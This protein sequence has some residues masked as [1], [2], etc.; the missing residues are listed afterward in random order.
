MCKGQY[1]NGEKVTWTKYGDPTEITWDALFKA[2]ALLSVASVL[3]RKVPP[4][5]AKMRNEFWKL[6]IAVLWYHKVTEEDC[7]RLLQQL[8]QL[9]MTM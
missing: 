2:N 6:A 3:L 8:Q 5:G 4:A 7:I 1:D 9:M